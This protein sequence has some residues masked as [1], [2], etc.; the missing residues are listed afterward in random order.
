MIKVSVLYPH[1][2]GA[3]FDMR[4]YRDEHIPMLERLVG[5]A[6]LAVEIDEGMSGAAP[7][8]PP[9]Y[10]AAAHLYFESLASFERNFGPHGGEIRADIRNYTDIRPVVQI[11]DVVRAAKR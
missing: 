10:A 2:E 7:G 1:T 5:A 6:L 4:Y 9:P 8:S 11:A 3:K